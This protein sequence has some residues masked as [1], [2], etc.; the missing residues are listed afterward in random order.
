MAV[1]SI[2]ERPDI[3]AQ[4]RGM[5]AA[6]A[7]AWAEHSAYA[8]ARGAAVAEAMLASTAPRPGEHVLELACGPGGLGLAAAPLVAPDGEVVLSD[9]VPEMTAIAAGRAA[10]LGI[11][12]VHARD[13]DLERIDE[14]DSS[15]DVVLCREGLMFVPDPVAAAREIARVL[16]PGGRFAIAVWGPRDR[17]PWLGIVFDAV[18]AHTG[19]PVPPPNVPGPFSLADEVELSRIFTAAGLTDVR[20]A[21][22]PVPMR[23]ASFEEWWSRTCALAGPLAKRLATLP[24]RDAEQIRTRAREAARPYATSTGLE[25]TGV[26]L[27]ASGGAHQS[28]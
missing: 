1:D 17:N 21:E 8:D 28:P 4:L 22:H 11:G 26:T 24:E 12:N 14:P 9:V 3:R 25:F 2:I 15:Y 7:P 13:L 23:A 10:T 5:W 16:R 6:V 18:S 19:E 20:V 27:L